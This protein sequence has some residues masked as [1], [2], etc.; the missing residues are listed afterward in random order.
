MAGRLSRVSS[1]FPRAASPGAWLALVTL[2]AAGAPVLVTDEED[3]ARATFTFWDCVT[4]HKE[5]WGSRRTY[6]QDPNVIFDIFNEPRADS[7]ASAHGPYNLKLWRNGGPGPGGRNQPAYQGMDGVVS[8]IRTYDHAANLLWV[9]GPGFADTLAGLDRGCQPSPNCLISASLGPVVYAIHHPYVG[10]AAQ[11]NSATRR[12][13]FGSL[14]DQPAAPV[15]A[16]VV[17][18]EWTTIDA[19]NPADTGTAYSPYCWPDAPVSPLL[20]AALTS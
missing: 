2:L 10:P 17:V 13:D 11:A 4:Q 20:T 18:G 6:A 15:R 19:A 7:C 16:P 5:N 8:R 9:E 3:P 12:D 14:V 1:P